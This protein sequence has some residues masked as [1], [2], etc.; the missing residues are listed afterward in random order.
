MSDEDDKELREAARARMLEDATRVGRP[1]VRGPIEQAF[2]ALRQTTD[3][4]LL[5]TSEHAYFD[6]HHSAANL[7]QATELHEKALLT[8]SQTLW[9]CGTRETYPQSV[10]RVFNVLKGAAV[11]LYPRSKL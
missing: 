3:A 9:M 8:M 10:Q 2:E 7:R 11:A 1:P 5:A 6:T 4:L